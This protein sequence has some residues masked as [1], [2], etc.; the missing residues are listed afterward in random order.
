MSSTRSLKPQ[1]P[2]PELV[3][4]NEAKQESEMGS[5]ADASMSTKTTREGRRN[6]P[7]EKIQILP[8]QQQPKR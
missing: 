8:Q 1:P 5:A 2:I 6:K 7:T 3:K 4:G